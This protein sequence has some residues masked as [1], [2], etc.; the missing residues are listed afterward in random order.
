M[1]VVY[2]IPGLM[3]ERDGPGGVPD[4]EQELC[5]MEMGF[6]ISYLGRFVNVSLLGGEIE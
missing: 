4:G 2:T 6:Y 5:V 1:P 3:T